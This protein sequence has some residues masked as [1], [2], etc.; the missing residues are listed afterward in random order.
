M[1]RA[2]ILS[3][4]LT[5][6]LVL[7]ATAQAEIAMTETFTYQGQLESDGVFVNGTC[8]FD[9]ALWDNIIG[10]VL[11]GTDSLSGVSVE[12]GL[13]TVALNFPV[14]TFNGNSRA[15][16]IT[17]CCDPDDCTNPPTNF[18][19][20]APRQELTPAPNALALPGLRTEWVLVSPPD[21]PNI[22]GGFYDNSVTAN[23]RGGT[24]SGGGSDNDGFGVPI[25]NRVTDH[26]STV[27]GGGDNQAGDNNGEV[28]N[29][30]FATVGGGR[31]NI[32]SSTTATVAG[33][34][35]NTASASSATVSGGYQNQASG[36]N[37]TVAGGDTNVASGNWSAIGGG[38]INTAQAVSATVAGGLNN[39]AIMANSTVGGGSQNNA[40]GASSTVPGGILNTAAG[41]Y[42]FAAGRRAKANHDGTFVWADENSGIGSD[43]VSTN[44][45]QFLIR[46]SGGVG[47]GT[48]TPSASLDVVGVAKATDFECTNCIDSG[49]IDSAQVQRRVNG[50]CAS[51]AIQSINADGT[52]ACDVDAVGS[53]GAVNACS[54]VGGVRHFEYK[55]SINGT[56]DIY[57]NSYVQI[58]RISSSTTFR[59]ACVHSSGCTYVYYK[60]G[61]RT[62]GTLVIG[63]TVDINVSP[64]GSDIRF[65]FAKK[66]SGM[67]MLSC[68]VLA[69]NG[70]WVHFMCHDTQ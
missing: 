54:Y 36:M 41:D 52:V 33:G 29:A 31:G 65:L 37:A 56:T 43:F 58:K 35:Q 61:V 8:E 14:G 32:A 6:C 60:N 38:A 11:I 18:V 7:G 3:K 48:N 1:S 50:V 25:L 16:E 39:H 63:G 21:S 2:H 34:L 28:D 66:T 70:Q 26:F 45:N 27:S 9:F 44:I 46:A 67:D 20:L 53:C 57:A 23:V 49:D 15:L 22:I 64:N 47:I 19:T 13:F 17:V 62:A 4:V 5:A 59:L 10:G 69:T 42:S 68:D 51:G 40:T 24:I 12:K 55:D 30:Q